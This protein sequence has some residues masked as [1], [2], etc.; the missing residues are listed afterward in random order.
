[1]LLANAK[2]ELSKITPTVS[3]RK[4]EIKIRSEVVL[5]APNFADL[6]QQCDQMI[7]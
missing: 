5:C 7:E 1:M 4:N 6:C 3:S 2:V